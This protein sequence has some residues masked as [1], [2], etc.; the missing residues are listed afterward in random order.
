MG[1]KPP[2]A[3]AVPD[4][5]PPVTQ[6]SRETLQAQKDTQLQAAGRKGF[7]QTILA[8]EG[9]KFTQATSSWGQKTLLG[10]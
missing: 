7:K 6:S 3:P 2:P 5:I 8:G 1:S 4:P 10:S 9:E